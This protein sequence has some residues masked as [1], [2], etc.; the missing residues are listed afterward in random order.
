MRMVGISFFDP[1]LGRAAG[2]TQAELVSAA[3]R[4]FGGQEHPKACALTRLAGDANP[5]AMLVHD[6]RD[7]RESES[8]PFLL[9]G[10]EGVEDLFTKLGRNTR[11]R[12]PHVDF[13]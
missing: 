7:D 9:G 6:L 13:N 2:R 12:I 8:D 11:S 1:I 3:R 10:K 5:P 4:S